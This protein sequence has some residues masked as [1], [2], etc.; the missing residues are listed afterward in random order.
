LPP[1]IVD[2]RRRGAVLDGPEAFIAIEFGPN[3]SDR[4]EAVVRARR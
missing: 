4:P 1:Q 3:K 2:V